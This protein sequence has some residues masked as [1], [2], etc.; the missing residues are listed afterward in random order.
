MKVLELARLT[1]AQWVAVSLFEDVI[2]LPGRVARESSGSAFGPGSPARY[3]VIAGVPTIG[4]M[5]IAYATN[6]DPGRRRPLGLALIGTLA[7]A[8]LTGVLVRT[9]NVPLI[10]G[11]SDGES[12]ERLVRRWHGLNKLRLGLLAGVGIALDRAARH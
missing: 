7:A 1:N 2:D 8:G 10:T 12:S 3:H 4:S 5:I 6:P 11:P 9:V